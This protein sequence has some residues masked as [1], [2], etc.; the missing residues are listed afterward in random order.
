MP[1]EPSVYI[2]LVDPMFLTS[3]VNDGIIHFG[4]TAEYRKIEETMGNSWI[5][6]KQDGLLTVPTKHLSEFKSVI[7]YAGKSYSVPV[8]GGLSMSMGMDAFCFTHIEISELLNPN[9]RTKLI[10]DLNNSLLSDPDFPKKVVYFKD[11]SIF[12][13]RLMRCLEIAGYESAIGNVIYDKEPYERAVWIMKHLPGSGLGST[14]WINFVKAKKFSIER[15]TR[16]II[17]HRALFRNF[18]NVKIGS[19]CSITNCYDSLADFIKD[20]YETNC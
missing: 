16:I 4:S 6:D 17:N 19:I 3:F 18:E 9:K 7:T 1:R 13:K 5:G 11:F 12:K 8:T 15:E 14:F 2:K 10:K 20:F